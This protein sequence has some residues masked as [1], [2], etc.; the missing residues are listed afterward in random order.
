MY[1]QLNDK[2][3]V[4]LVNTYLSNL[5][6]VNNARELTRKEDNIKLSAQFS[7]LAIQ[8]TK[9]EGNVSEQDRI[10]EQIQNLKKYV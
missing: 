4:E 1:L 5:T 6:N 10:S 3:R 9:A 7:N 8:F 2:E